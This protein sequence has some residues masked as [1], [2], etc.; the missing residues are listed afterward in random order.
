M[1]ILIYLYFALVI[2]LT[3]STNWIIFLSL[4][5]TEVVVLGC[6]MR[7]K[8]DRSSRIQALIEPSDPS[9]PARRVFVLCFLIIAMGSIIYWLAF[10]PGG[11]NLDAYGQWG[12]AHGIMRYNDW[13]PVTSTLIIQL[14]S[15]ICDS[16]AFCI[17]IQ[18]IAFSLAMALLLT[19]LYGYGVNSRIL[20]LIAT[21]VSINPAIG[22]NTI[23]LTK[24]VQYT[25]FSVLLFDILIRIYFSNGLWLTGFIHCVYIALISAMLCLVRHNGILFVMP[26]L[27]L[28]LLLKQQKIRY[29]LTSA[30]LALVCIIIVKVPLSQYLNVTPHENPVGEA[31][32]IP[33]AIMVNALVSEPDKLPVDVHNFLNDIADDVSWK[34]HYITGEWDSC[35]WEFGGASLLADVSP[36]KI[37]EYTLLTIRSCPE[38]AYHSIRENTRIV[39][40]PLISYNYWVPKVYI[41]DNDYGIRPAP[42]KAFSLI[43]ELLIRASFCFPIGMLCWNTGTHIIVIMIVF[44]LAKGRKINSCSY[45]YIPLLVY[46]FGTMLFLAGPNQR[47]FYCNTVL[48]LP[49]VICGLFERGAKVCLKKL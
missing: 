30:M 3:V 15:S 39:W 26:M 16:F 1:R 40:E 8:W 35:K 24:D 38:S 4:L 36:G 11:F 21:Y 34:N 6:L 43:A 28:V 33:M 31:M 37:L 14:F 2:A 12:Q 25:I 13:H 32:G 47:Y 5:S 9:K 7:I 46:D 49:I 17:L 22:L 42:V 23:S 45:L 18:I 44:L 29:I 19:T 41:E 48:F 20:L 27:L 10:Y